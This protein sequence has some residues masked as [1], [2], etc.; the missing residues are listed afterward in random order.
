MTNNFSFFDTILYKQGGDFVWTEQP[1]LKIRV[2]MLVTLNSRRW[3][4]Q[5]QSFS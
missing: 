5:R 2:L 4:I 3:L 1:V